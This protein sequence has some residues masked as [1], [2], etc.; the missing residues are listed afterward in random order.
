VAARIA[1]WGVTAM[2][3][4]LAAVVALLVVGLS[5]MAAE[6]K[7]QY[8]SN[9]PDKKTVTLTIDGK[10][11]TFVLA[12]DFKVINAKNKDVKKG[13]QGKVFSTGPQVIVV[14]EGEGKKEIVKEV[15]VAGKKKK[16]QDQ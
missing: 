11:R 14:T 7:G 3:R 5:L 2:P 15:R 6:Y 10:D 8:K 4:L 12:D 1:T 9:D 16:N 13:L